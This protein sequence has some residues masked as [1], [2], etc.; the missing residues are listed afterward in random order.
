LK[1]KDIFIKDAASEGPAWLNEQRSQYSQ[2]AAQC[3]IVSPADHRK[4]K[5]LSL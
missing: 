3:G 1:N 4:F 5:L 2:L